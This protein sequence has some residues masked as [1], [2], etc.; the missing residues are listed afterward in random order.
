MVTKEKETEK[1]FAEEIAKKDQEITRKLKEKEKK[2]AAEMSNAKEKNHEMMTKQK[3][4]AKINEERLQ[5]MITKLQEEKEQLKRK[6][7]GTEKHELEPR[8]KRRISQKDSEGDGSESDIS[9]VLEK[10][11]RRTEVVGVFTHK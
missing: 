3:E 11:K 9:V 10:I 4:M 5:E 1:M 8:E 7:K 6:V 2:F